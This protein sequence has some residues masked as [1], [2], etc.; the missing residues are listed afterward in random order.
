M[1]NEL[2]LTAAGCLPVSADEY[3]AVDVVLAHEIVSRWLA[4]HPADDGEPVT[5]KFLQS[6]GAWSAGKDNWWIIGEIDG[7]CIW[8]WECDASLCWMA[9]INGLDHYWP[10]DIHV[11]GQVRGLLRECGITTNERSQA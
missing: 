2:L 9:Y 5:L 6:L 3:T 4:E 11:R 7:D 10:H 1:T 8:F